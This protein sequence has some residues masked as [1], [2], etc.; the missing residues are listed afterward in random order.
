MSNEGNEQVCKHVACSCPARE[1]SD[2]CSEE[3]EKALVDTDCG[4]G[5]PECRAQA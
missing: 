2:Y 3:C 1:D 5:H 4:C